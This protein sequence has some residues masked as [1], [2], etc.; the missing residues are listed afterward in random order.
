MSRAV[1]Q[2]T[3]G[4]RES[5][6]VPQF[7]MLCRRW[8]QLQCFAGRTGRTAGCCVA[9]KRAQYRKIRPFPKNLRLK[10]SSFLPTPCFYYYCYQH[11]IIALLLYCMTHLINKDSE[12][13]R[14]PQMKR[15]KNIYYQT[16]VLSVFFKCIYFPKSN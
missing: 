16:I 7:V 6:G 9:R 2:Y 8:A 1:W 13:T 4:V 14:T 11:S 10:Y 12:A 3:Q 15:W 5:A